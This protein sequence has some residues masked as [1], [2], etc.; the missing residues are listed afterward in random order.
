MEIQ[1]AKQY[2][3]HGDR[4]ASSAARGVAVAGDFAERVHGAEEVAG[5]AA[6]ADSLGR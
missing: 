2:S 6:K 4:T 1:Q 5:D 3:A